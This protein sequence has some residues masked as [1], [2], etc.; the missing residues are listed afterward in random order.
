MLLVAMICVQGAL[1]RTIRILAIGNSFSE[2]AV[3]QYL[4]ELGEH[5]G[6]EM[7][8]GNLYIGGC[9]LEKHWKNAE[10]DKPA[11]RYRKIDLQNQSHWTDNMKISTAL[12]DEPWDYISLQQASGSSGIQET[13]EP[14]LKNLV[15]YIHNLAPKSKIVWH[16][17]WAYAKTSDHGEFPKYGR[18]QLRMYDMINAAAKKGMKENK[19]KKV[20]P[21]GTTIQNA[22]N[23]YIG[24]N[25][26]RD[27]YHLHLV[28]GR[29]AA[30]CTWYEAL[31]GR[32][33]T[34]NTYAPEGVDAKMAATIQKCAH[35]AVRHPWKVTLLK[36]K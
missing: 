7:I 26:N 13:Y 6:V 23:T 25:M 9:P 32:K 27:G 5:D 24:D 3:E 31:T 1:A 16:Q 28:H 15:A 21:S 12:T 30:A 36:E 8:I 14:Y 18:D 35:N 19:I 17:T 22:R 33:V 34:G 11:Y 29:Y 2:D 20:V 4:H 10:A